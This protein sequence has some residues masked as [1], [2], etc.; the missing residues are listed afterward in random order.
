MGWDEAG[1]NGDVAAESATCRPA[2][3]RNDEEPG[4]LPLPH[5]SVSGSVSPSES[6]TKW[7]MRFDPDPDS[8]LDHLDTASIGDGFGTATWTSPPPSIGANHH[9]AGV[10]ERWDRIE[11]WEGAARDE[12]GDFRD[13]PPVEET[14]GW[15]HTRIASRGGR[16]VRMGQ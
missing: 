14:G 5:A 10:G 6:K 9:G 12:G 3:A 2:T 1:E 4:W 13:E 11:G 15:V 8:E 7:S 16:R